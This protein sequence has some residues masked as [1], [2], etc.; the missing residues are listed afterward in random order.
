M[1]KFIRKFTLFIPFC[2]TIYLI[3]IT[4]WGFLVP[5]RLK[6]NLY[7]RIGSKG[8]SFTRLKEAKTIENIDILFVGSSHAYRGFDTRIFEKYNISTFNLG[9]SNQSPI[10][11]FY[12]L[13]E[14]CNILNPKL[15]V[16]EVYPGAFA[17]DGVESSLDIISNDDFNSKMID[18]ALEINNLKTY[19]TLI[20]AY[21]YHLTGL[22]QSFEESSV[23]DD[24]T[25]ISGG[26]TEKIIHYY[27]PREQENNKWEIEIIQIEYFEKCI[28]YLNQ[29]EIEFLLVQAPYS[30]IYYNSFSNNSYIDSFFVN[31]GN[32]YNFNE[33]I[34]LDDSLHFN[35]RDHLNHHGVEIFN[36]SLIELLFTNQNKDLD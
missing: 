2:L 32:Y 1:K 28:E 21:I 22:R 15:V 6:C 10:Q 7:F 19:N 27:S 3:L 14:Y 25:Y 8:H 23:H 31:Y 30:K 33:I 16:F 4:I 17:N 34:S 29:N 24:D 9:S 11:T 5:N 12:L 26:F 35:D 18:M 20:F 36:E 13:E